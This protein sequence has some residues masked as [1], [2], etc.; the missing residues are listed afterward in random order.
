MK[1]LIF[2]SG[3]IISFAMNGLLPEL[4]KLKE[5]FDGK[6]IITKEVK[7]ETV[8]KP[9]NIKI[10]E[11]DALKIKILI[12]NKVFESPEVLGIKDY[13]IENEKRKILDE[14]NKMFYS[15]NQPI[16]IIH[17]G[18]ASCLALNKILL[19]REID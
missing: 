17:E 10:F 9:L 7:Y 4:K 2:D 6:F 19:K 13:E 11:L 12:D 3:T 15:Q 16:E 18:E 1:I 5:V 8:D 14:T